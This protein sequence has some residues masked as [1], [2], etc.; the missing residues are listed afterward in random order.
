METVDR[1]DSQILLNNIKS[2]KA[3]QTLNKIMYVK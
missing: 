1:P 2:H 3:I